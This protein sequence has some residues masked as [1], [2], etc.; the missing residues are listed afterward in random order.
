MDDIM[1]LPDDKKRIQYLEEYR[2]TNGSLYDSF[3]LNSLVDLLLTTAQLESISKMLKMLKHRHGRM[4]NRYLAQYHEYEKLLKIQKDQLHSD[5]KRC[6]D[7]LINF[8]YTPKFIKYMRKMGWHHP[9]GHLISKNDYPVLSKELGLLHS[10]MHSPD[11]HDKL[12]SSV[13]R[14][15]DF[16]RKMVTGYGIKEASNIS[17]LDNHTPPTSEDIDKMLERFKFSKVSY[18]IIPPMFNNPVGIVIPLNDHKSIDG[19]SEDDS[20]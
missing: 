10:R 13:L 8:G 6:R 1:E 19:S 5:H 4:Y 14:I 16:H 20:E 2:K 7:N 9:D 11:I 12:M 17:R 3:A 18:P 15:P